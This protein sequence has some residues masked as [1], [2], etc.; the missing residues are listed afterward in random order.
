MAKGCICRPPRSATA[1]SL[2][3][4]FQVH[5]RYGLHLCRKKLTTLDHSNAAASCYQDVGQFLEQN[6]NPLAKLLLLLMF[7]SIDSA[8][9]SKYLAV[10]KT[11]KN[12]IYVRSVLRSCSRNFRV[13]HTF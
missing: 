12:V 13:I 6:F 4:Y 5:L 10:E 11:V 7:D 2:R 3:G 9:D 1:F 8:L